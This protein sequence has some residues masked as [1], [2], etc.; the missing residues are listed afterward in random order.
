MSLV[1]GKY[2]KKRI[3]LN[4]ELDLTE[5]TKIELVVYPESDISNY[6]GFLKNRIKESSV[7]YIRKIRKPRYN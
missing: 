1:K 3:I 7:E 5:N 6:F 2:K 4:K